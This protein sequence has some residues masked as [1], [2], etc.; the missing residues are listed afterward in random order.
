VNIYLLKRHQPNQQKIQG[1]WVC[2]FSVVDTLSAKA[3]LVSR[4][5]GILM[6]EPR[7]FGC[8][9]AAIALLKFAVSG[10]GY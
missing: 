4:L 3:A 2:H 10:V 6:I 1:F 9:S 8:S 5:P 7:I